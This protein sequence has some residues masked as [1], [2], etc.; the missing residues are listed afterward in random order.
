MHY[1]DI[2]I[3]GFGMAL[4]TPAPAHTPANHPD[5]PYLIIGRQRSADIDLDHLWSEDVQGAGLVAAA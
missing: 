4:T 2:I 3:N 5:R 1:T